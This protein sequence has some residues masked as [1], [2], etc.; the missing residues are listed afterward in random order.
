AL[1]AIKDLEV[2]AKDP[3]IMDVENFCEE[4]CSKWKT[5]IDEA[6]ALVDGPL[7]NIIISYLFNTPYYGNKIS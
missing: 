6:I 2:L 7:S 3:G 4:Y 5:K 1:K